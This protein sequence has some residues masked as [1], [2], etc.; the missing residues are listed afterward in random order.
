MKT[1]VRI[2]LFVVLAFVLPEQMFS[3][4]V[5]DTL[6]L[7]EFEVI[8]I[9]DD[10]SQTYKQT[11]IDTL[12]RK[13][14]EHYD[15]G[16][17]LTAFSP[18]FIKSY[19]KGSI[20]SASFRGTAASHTQVLWNGFS[21][22]SPMLGQV[23][24]SYIPDSFFNEIKLLFGGG[25][26]FERGGALGGAVLLDNFTDVTKRPLFHINQSA[27][28]F[29]T[30]NTAVNVN[31]GKGNF[32]SETGIIFQSSKNDFKYYN[33]GVIPPEYMKQE[34]ASYLNTGFQQHF[35]SKYKNGR[36]DFITWNQWN[37]RN[38]PPI[39]TNVLKGG[40]PEEYQNSFFSRNILNWRYF[41]NKSAFTVKAAWFYENQHYFLRTTTQDSSQVSLIDSKNKTNGFYLKSSFK[42][43]LFPGWKVFSGIDLSFDKVKSNNYED[44]KRRNTGSL[45][46]GVEK[47]FNKRL[48]VNLLL[49]EE[50]AGGVFLPPMFFAGINYKVLSNEGLFLRATASKNFHLPTLNDLY[51]YPGGNP[52]L[53]PES[54]TEYDAGLNYYK[55]FSGKLVVSVDV[56]GYYSFINDWIQWVPSDYRYWTPL[57]ISYVKARGVEVSTQV[58]G[59]I[60]DINYKITGKYAFTKTTDE[61]DKAVEGNYSGR[62]L[63][64]I[65]V[66]H[67]N[68]FVYLNF[69]GW[70][71]GWLTVF[72]GKRNTSLDEQNSFSNVLPYYSLNNVN[73]GKKL[74]FKKTDITVDIKVNN[75]FNVQYQAVL[76]R[77]MPGINFE[78]SL[79][80]DIR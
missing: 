46:A 73:F 76:W 43:E 58:T 57:N 33:N 40:N 72:T 11:E 9:K 75:I 36:F 23:D 21:I 14:F 27:G 12:E 59:V 49:R 41:K 35:S 32:G 6:F 50:V 63:I 26:L 53:K 52:N 77:A 55:S 61:S 24:F 51:W 80:F 37:N 16:E 2:L 8:G 7:N 79:Q 54:A 66:H 28:S 22:N 10:Y 20:S 68:L 67:G 78:I 15:L 45:H 39:M 60:N 48:F 70:S 17:L 42:R 62:Q 3:Q 13:I 65:P 44:V 47:S 5:F 71:A 56:T 38:I 19:G 29:K 31:A 74:E 25:S 34:N 18:V 1:A 64:Y 30:F 69:K 4:A